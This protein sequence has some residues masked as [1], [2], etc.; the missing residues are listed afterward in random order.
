M[1]Q[2]PAGG[3]ASEQGVERGGRFPGEYR[4]QT[5]GAQARRGEQSGQALG[6][7]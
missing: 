5:E 1:P 7:Q 4:H 2:D 6:V 3:G